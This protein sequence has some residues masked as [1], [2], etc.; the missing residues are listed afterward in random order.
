ME[1]MSTSICKKIDND[2]IREVGIPSIVLMENAAKEVADRIMN[3]DNKFIVFCGHGNNGG[4]GLAIARKLINENKDVCVVIVNESN[5]YSEDFLIN[6]NILKKLTDNILYIRNINDI[7]SLN[8]IIEKY[9]IV[10]DCIFGIGL[11]R[12]LEEFYVSLINFINDKAKT[13]ISVDTPS[14]LNTNDGRV[15]GTSV[16]ANITYTFEVLKRG[17]IEYK[18]LEY[19]GKVEV[20]KIGIP[21]FIKIKNS[22]GIHILEKE[23]YRRLMKKRDVYGHKG[24]YGK[25]CILAGSKGYTGAAYIATEAC[26]RAGAGLTT[27]I[28]N[29]YVQDKLSSKVVEAMIANI[30]DKENLNRLFEISNVFAI[31]PGIDKELGYKDIFENLLDLDDKKFVI[32]AGAFE[33]IKN[34]KEIIKKLKNRAVFTPHPGEMAR[35]IDRDIDYIENNRI[36]VARKFAKENDIIVLLKGYN[37]IITNGKDIYIN[38]TGNSKM[39]SGGMGD[40]LTGIITALLAQ[41]YS[42]LNSALI[43]AYVHGLAGE[44]A[45]KD[46]YSTI[47]SEVIENISKAMNYI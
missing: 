26:V 27:L 25:A 6:F 16:R 7:Y 45:S 22:E 29:K 17:F 39:A 35:L 3:L 12:V 23:E 33:I 36:E 32:D 14:G 21:N 40:C 38:N 4:D 34:N 43:G 5:N 31:G 30:E 11:N 42:I 2:T 9:E 1:V 47:A 41:G 8:K 46:K 18:A 19:L 24:T 10:I 37:T 28:T 13:V 44:I 20:L 15:M